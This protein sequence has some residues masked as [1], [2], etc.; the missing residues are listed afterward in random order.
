MPAGRSRIYVIPREGLAGRTQARVGETGLAEKRRE[1]REGRS[2]RYG[3]GGGENLFRGLA[4]SHLARSDP[5]LNPGTFTRAAHYRARAYRCANGRVMN[6]IMKL[7]ATLS[8]SSS[9]L[10]SSFSLSSFSL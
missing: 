2:A 4:N 10:L 5:R 1:E 3:G 6:E 9:P 8:L 7:R